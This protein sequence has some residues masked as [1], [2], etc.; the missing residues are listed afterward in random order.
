[1]K[2]L[3]L[4]SIAML[5]ISNMWGFSVSVKN[6]TQTKV[7]CYLVFTDLQ[8]VF[9]GS[10]STSNFSKGKKKTIAKGT[11]K[12]LSSK[13]TPST[14]K[15]CVLA[16]YKDK[17]PQQIRTTNNKLDATDNLKNITIT[18]DDLGSLKFTPAQ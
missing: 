13:N 17:T 14:L 6:S 2:K 11:T 18:T 15:A 4:L 12:K 16:C 3:L 9:G 8:S 7:T 1:M 5:S 10:A